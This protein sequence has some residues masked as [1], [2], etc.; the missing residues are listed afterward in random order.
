[1]Y[2]ASMVTDGGQPIALELTWIDP[3]NPDPDPPE[4]F[5]ADRWTTV[6]F[7]ARIPVTAASLVELAKAT[8]PGTSSLAVHAPDNEPPIA[9]WGMVDFGN[10]PHAVVHDGSHSGQDRPGLFQASIVGIGHLSISVA[11][12]PVAELRVDQIVGGSGFDALNSGPVFGVLEEGR[13]HLVSGVRQAVSPEI[14]DERNYWE[15]TVSAQWTATFAG[16]LLRLGGTD[17]EGGVVITPDTSF[18]GLDVKYR[19]VYARLTTALRRS[20]VARIEETRASDSTWEAIQRYEPTIDAETYMDEGIAR[21]EKEEAENEIDGAIRFIALLSRIDGLVVL[22][23]DLSVR[24]FGAAITIED[25]LDAVFSA[26]DEFGGPF[27]RE[28]RSPEEFGALHRGVMRYCNTAPGSVGFVF[29]SVGDVHCITRVD[30]VLVIWDGI[31]LTR[32]MPGAQPF[33]KTSARPSAL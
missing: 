24:G 12:A 2:A 17:H 8:D 5:A 6:P 32:T 30:D 18:V 1:M 29:S 21:N 9:M 11:L 16:L 14:F 15:E 19:L 13:R 27:R 10:R 3:G 33:Q 31:Q 23:P 7:S 25:E 22:T 4:R 26:E 20:A 28:R